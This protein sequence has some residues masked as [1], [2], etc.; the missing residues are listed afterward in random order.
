MA[1]IIKPPAPL[2]TDANT[3]T[4]FLAGS[5]DMGLAEDWQAHMEAALADLDVIVLN[6]RRAQWD[7]SWVQS[8]DNDL[9]RG[10]VEWEL[11]ALDQATVVAMYFAPVTKAPI[12][13]LELGLRAHKGGIIVCCPDGYWRKGN[14]E[15]VCRRHGIPLAS[16]LDALT[17]EVRRRLQ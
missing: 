10:Q 6:P 3:R 5:I 2:P 4:V 15:I 1:L 13:L 17:A 16:S 8:I 9:F 7:S 12:T 14:V 11:A